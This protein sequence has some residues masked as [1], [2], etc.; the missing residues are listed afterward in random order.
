MRE[1]LELLSVT[2]T[3]TKTAVVFLL[4]A[5][6]KLANRMGNVHGGAAALVFD[7]CTTMCAAPLAREDFWRFGG[8]SRTLSITYLRPA[9]VGMEILVECEVLQIGAR[10]ATIRGVMRD[11]TTGNILSVAEHNKAAIALGGSKA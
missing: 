1:S 5:G 3:P 8:V 10:L 4:K 9:K 11:K 6:S 7:M 2:S